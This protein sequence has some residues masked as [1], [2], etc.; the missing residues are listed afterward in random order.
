MT[1]SD[2][3][4]CCRKDAHFSSTSTMNCLKSQRSFILFLSSS[5][6]IDDDVVVCLVYLVDE[7]S[8]NLGFCKCD[9]GYGGADCGLDLTL[10]P[11][12]TALD[13]LGLCD[14]RTK[15][16]RDVVVIAEQLATKSG[17]ELKCVIEIYKVPTP[18]RSRFFWGCLIKYDFRRF[19]ALHRSNWST[20]PWSV[21]LVGHCRTSKSSADCPS[22]RSTSLPKTSSPTL[23]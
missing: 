22:W 1:F 23:T 2:H 21:S 17:D 18:K 13:N 14:V 9:R 19:V 3:P 7:V 6:K 10:G 11:H 16:C 8:F 12:V 15:P 4:R 20:M 5:S